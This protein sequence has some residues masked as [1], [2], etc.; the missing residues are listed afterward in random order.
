VNCA[1]PKLRQAFEQAGFSDV[2]TLLS[3]GN[4]LFS[5]P[6]TSLPAIEKKAEAAM[7][8]HLGLR[9]FTIVRSVEALRE[10]L[11]S[12]PYKD[13]PAA[14]GAKRIVTF[15]RAAPKVELELPIERDGARVLVLRGTEL[16]SDYLPTPKGPV[17][18]TLIEKA[19][20]KEQTTR[21]W[22]TVEKLA[23]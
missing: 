23:R 5:T 3:S 12:D 21:T 9:F 8:K 18:M 7:E 22:Q 14:P 16:F 10:L 20:G 19:L 13:F 4:V 6:S 11:A 15:L 2:K 1:M 17:F